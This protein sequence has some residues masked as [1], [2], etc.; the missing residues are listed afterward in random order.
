LLPEN[1]TIANNLFSL[2]EGGT[3]LK[4]QQG[5]AFKWMGNM[6]ATQNAGSTN[7]QAGIRFV[8][9]QLSRGPDGLW[10]PSPTVS[11][12]QRAAQGRFR[13]IKTDIDG[14]PRK[15]RLDVG[16]DQIS[17]APILNRPLTAADVGPSWN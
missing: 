11:E 4:G 6:A 16:C 7:R 10:R 13:E 12:V 8:E 15:G 14:Q 17:Q 3:L 5:K 2:P 9:A 1:I